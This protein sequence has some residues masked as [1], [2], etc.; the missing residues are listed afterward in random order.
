LAGAWIAAGVEVYSGGRKVFSEDYSEI[1]AN[2][3]LEPALFDAE[4]F[5][6]THWR[7]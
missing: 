1:E 6:S 3:K 2:V 5:R 4:K 7:K